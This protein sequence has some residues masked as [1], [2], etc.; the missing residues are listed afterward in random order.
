MKKTNRQPTAREVAH[1]IK[2]LPRT[3]DGKVIYPG[4]WAYRISPEGNMSEWICLAMDSVASVSYMN[5][6]IKLTSGH[7][8][9]G[10]P[11]GKVNIFSTRASALAECRRRNRGNK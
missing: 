4:M 5:K 2:S 6:E 7:T 10:E 11:R 8:L 1:V 9:F 3:A